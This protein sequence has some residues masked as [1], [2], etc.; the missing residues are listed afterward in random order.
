MAKHPNLSVSKRKKH[1]HYGRCSTYDVLCG[2]DFSVKPNYSSLG[3]SSM[4]NAAGKGSK[5]YPSIT[6]HQLTELHS[7]LS[8][9]VRR[10]TELE[11]DPLRLALT[12]LYSGEKL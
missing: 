4:V 6:T 5:G 7:G 9:V 2:A 12:V 3:S 10:T 8:A 11:V 1:C